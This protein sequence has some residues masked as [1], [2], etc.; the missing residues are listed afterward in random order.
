MN[1]HT[2]KHIVDSLYERSHDPRKANVEVVVG[3]KSYWLKSFQQHQAVEGVIIQLCETTPVI[4]QKI[5]EAEGAKV[6]FSDARDLMSDFVP[7]EIREDYDE[8]T[9]SE[10]CRGSSCGNGW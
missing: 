7:P 3:N 2:L 9:R 4:E 8:A 1:L 10:K 6:T 5:A